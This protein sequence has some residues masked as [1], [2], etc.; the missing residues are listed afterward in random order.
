MERIFYLYCL[1][2]L[3]KKDFTINK[4]R[5]VINRPPLKIIMM[6]QKVNYTTPCASI[7]SATFTKPAILAPFT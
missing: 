1:R 7:A 2:L 4:R 3:L 6:I 5:P